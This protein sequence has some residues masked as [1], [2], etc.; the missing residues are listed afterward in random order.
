[1][2]RAVDVLSF[3][4]TAS[5]GDRGSASGQRILGGREWESGLA[6]CAGIGC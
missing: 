4:V 5:Q 3:W 6:S 1:M 2:L